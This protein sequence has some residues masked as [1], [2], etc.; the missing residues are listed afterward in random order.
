MKKLIRAIHSS[1]SQEEASSASWPPKPLTD[2]PYDDLL[3]H[4]VASMDNYKW[5][6]HFA[7]LRQLR[8]QTDLS[9]KECDI[10]VNDYY[11]RKDP[12][13][14]SWQQT[15]QGLLPLLMLM[16][17]LLILIMCITY[18]HFRTLMKG[19]SHEDKLAFL[20]LIATAL[21]AQIVL[22]ILLVLRHIQ[23]KQHLD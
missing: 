6:S 19:L 11:I 23:A 20:L 10:I 15:G 14:L 12:K 3:V 21:L 18:L 7:L 4:I 16:L 22:A 8:Q 2:S 9:L 1:K 5:G 17:P 13:R